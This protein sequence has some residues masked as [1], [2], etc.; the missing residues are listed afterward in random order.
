MLFLLLG[1]C[2]LLEQ[3]I[4][5]TRCSKTEVFVDQAVRDFTK[6][7]D[8]LCMQS[9]QLKDSF[10]SEFDQSVIKVLSTI[11]IDR[12]K[13]DSFTCGFFEGLFGQVVF[14]LSDQRLCLGLRVDPWTF[15]H[16]FS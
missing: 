3:H 12:R 5:Q 16:R 7:L 8:L 15:K 9:L 11:H 14:C 6:P 4:E 13:K 2:G 1:A 10:P